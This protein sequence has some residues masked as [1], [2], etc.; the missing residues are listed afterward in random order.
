VLALD[1]PG[2]AESVGRGIHFT[3]S[4]FGDAAL[5]VHA[6]LAK[7]ADIDMDKLAIR[8]S[9]FGSYF[10]TVASAALGDRIK[11]YAVAGVCQEPGCHTIFNM[12]S[13]TFKARFMFM[14]GYDDEDAFDAFCQKIDL[15]PYAPKIKAPYMAIAGEN[16]QLS[17][18]EHTEALFKTIK[19]PKRLVIFE[20]ANHGV[21][22]APSVDNGEDKNTMLADWLLDRIDGKPCASERV[23]IDSSGVPHTTPFD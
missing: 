22:D 7:R 2:Q 9:S 14:S 6:A 16:D 19:A 17:P 3:D 12:A 18:I 1:G 11:G 13:P 23:W 21:G 8:S 20:G 5:A 10:G 15:R 4:N